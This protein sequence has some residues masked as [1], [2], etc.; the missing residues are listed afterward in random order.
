MFRVTPPLYTR[1]CLCIVDYGNQN[2]T[3]V[4]T[5]EQRSTLKCQQDMS[6]KTRT[7]GEWYQPLEVWVEKTEY[8]LCQDLIRL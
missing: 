8:V 5:P 6:D 3:R 1:L 7:P 2:Q 4:L